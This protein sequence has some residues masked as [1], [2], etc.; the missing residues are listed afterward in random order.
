MNGL[1]R[2]VHTLFRGINTLLIGVSRSF[3]GILSGPLV[4]VG[5]LFILEQVE[6][7]I[8]RSFIRVIVVVK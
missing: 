4:G 2:G 7:G 1:C 3:I 8:H 5:S 6:V